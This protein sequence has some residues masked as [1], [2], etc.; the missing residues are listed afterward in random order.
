MNYV[1]FLCFIYLLYISFKNSR[2]IFTP[3]NFFILVWFSNFFVLM[4]FV[5]DFYLYYA[6]SAFILLMCVIVYMGSYIGMDLKLNKKENNNIYQLPFIINQLKP[7]AIFLSLVGFLVVPM[8]IVSIKGDL[9]SLFNFKYLRHLSMYV[10]YIRY[11]EG[12]QFPISVQ[13]FLGLNYFAAL[14]NGSYFGYFVLNKKRKHF[15]IYFISIMTSILISII[16]TEKAVIIYTTLLFL[17]SFMVTYNALAKDEF[18]IS[19]KNSILF[20]S[21]FFFMIMIFIYVQMSRYGLSDYSGVKHVMKV[22]KVYAFG[23]ISAFS[24]WF[25]Y[26][27]SHI[28]PLGFGRFTFAGI[29][30]F[31][32]IYERRPGIFTDFSVISE[33]PLASNVYTAFR[34]LIIDFSM[35]GSGVLIF[36]FSILAGIAYSQYKNSILSFIYLILFYCISVLS[37]F[38]S[39]LNYNTLI[40]AFILLTI[41]LFYYHYTNKLGEK[42]DCIK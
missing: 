19:L 22:F 9:L 34:G 11:K 12:F 7:I 31:F 26:H 2:S 29:F 20:I 1:I 8:M 18:K 15:Y 36:I 3:S 32:H 5:H 30:S 40:A 6:A 17:S 38:T 24:I 16:T 37:L 42:N 23:H 39:L 28:T 33:E 14:L 21:L 4:F 10:S 25:K 35:I 41:T 13:M 27:I